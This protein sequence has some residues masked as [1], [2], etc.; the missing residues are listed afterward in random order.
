MEGRGRALTLQGVACHGHP[1]F[2]LLGL[3]RICGIVPLRG[4]G[5][6]LLSAPGE[7]RHSR[8]GRFH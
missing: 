4:V 3:W 1:V 8:P 2:V 6:N 5:L 7:D